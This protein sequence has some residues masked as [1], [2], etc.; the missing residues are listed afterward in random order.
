MDLTQSDVDHIRDW[1]GDTPDDATL[2]QYGEDATYWQEV[3]LRVLYRRRAN[4]AAGGSQASS[5]SLEGV[6]SV[7]LAKTDMS[8][9]DAQIADL[10]AQIAALNGAPVGGV[11]VA[12]MRRPDRYR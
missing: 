10:E 3:A 2:Y 6:L 4:A 12:R 11:T 8:T 7:G 9:L 1:V 5:F